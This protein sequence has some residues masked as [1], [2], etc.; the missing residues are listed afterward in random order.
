MRFTSTLIL[1]TFVFA[2]VHATSI[3]RS[4]DEEGPTKTMK[5]VTRSMKARS[6]KSTGKNNAKVIV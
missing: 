6:P 1:L 2:I 4:M 5:L 3:K